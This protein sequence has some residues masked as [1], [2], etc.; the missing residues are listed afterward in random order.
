MPQIIKTVLIFIFLVI[1]CCISAHFSLAAD[2]SLGLEYGEMTGLGQED[3]R[4][5]IANIIRIVLG[6]LGIV[7]VGLI[8]YAGWLWMSAEGNSEK[9]D[10]AKKVLIGAV[11]GLIICL[12]AFAIASFILSK[13][14]E[15]TSTS[16]PGGGYLDDTS[17]PGGGYSTLTR[18]DANTLTPECDIDSGFCD[19]NEYCG[20]DC[21][22]H[23]KGGYGDSCDGDPV[24]SECEVSS[25]MCQ[26]YLE[27][28]S[29]QDCE[30]L[31]APVIEWIS[32]VDVDNTPNGAPGNLITVGGRYFG[33]SV[34]EVIFAGKDTDNDGELFG[35]ADDQIASFPNEVNA[36][37]INYWQDNQIIV[38]VPDEAVDGPIKV[39]RT[40][41]E[42]DTTI[43]SRGPVIN[44]FDVNNM[45]RPG[46]CLVEP[47]KGYYGDVFALEGISFAGSEKQVLFGNEANNIKA[48]SISN[49]AD[50]SVEAVVPNINSGDNSI[51]V[52]IDEKNS[53]SLFFEVLYDS[54]DNPKIDYINPEK[55]PIGQYVTIYGSNFKN[56]YTDSSLVQFYLPADPDNLIYADID[57]VEECLEKFWQDTYIIVKVPKV[58]LG[59]YKVIVTNKDG[60]VSEPAD[61]TVT[62]GDPGPGTC[63][64]DPHNGP[65][66]QAVSV[67]GDNFGD[68]QDDGKTVFYNEISDTFISSWT[69]QKIETQVPTEAQTGSFKVVKDGNN[70]NTLQFTVGTCSSSDQCYLG[71]ECCSSDTYWAGICRDEGEC[72][73]EA[74]SE[75]VFGWTF[76]TAADS[77]ILNCSGYNT[78]E[79]CISTDM[80]PNSPGQCQTR[81]EASAGECGDDYCNNNYVECD[82]NCV[83]DGS[84]NQCKL[85]NQS[86]DEFNSSLILSYKAECRLVDNQVIW[87]IDSNEIS[88]PIGSFLDTNNWCSVG[89]LGVPEEC[90]LCENDFECQES[91]CVIDNQICPD[92]STCDN[93]ECVLD[94]SVC[95]C[96]CRVG[97]D[98]QDCC[99][100]LTCNPGNCGP[101]APDYGLC[102]G[103]RV[104]IDGQVNQVVSD[105]ACNCYGQPSRY[106]EV[107]DSD[108]PLGVCEDQVGQ[109]ESC[110]ADSSLASC[111]VNNS[112]CQTG[113]YCEQDSCTCQ[114][115]GSFGDSCDGDLGQSDCQI[116]NSMCQTGLYCEQDSCTCQVGGGGSGDLCENESVPACSI[117]ES[118]CLDS[119]E[120][121]NNDSDDCRCC[122]NPA[123]DQCSAPLECWANQT[124]CEGPSR[125][126]CCGCSSDSQC[127]GGIDGCGND[128]CCRA[129]PEI[130]QVNPA[131]NAVDVCKNILIS[132][133]FDQ[134]MD[135]ASFAENFIVA[136]DYGENQCPS[137][138]NFL[139]S[140]NKIKNKFI[141]KIVQILKP[142]FGERLVVLASENH[143][144]CAIDG[145]VDGYNNQ[146]G[147]G[148]ITF[149]PDNILDTDILYYAIVSGDNNITDSLVSGVSNTHG[150][151]MFG[152]DNDSFNAKQF[153]NS[154][155]WSFTVGQDICQLDYITVDPA[156]YLF[157]TAYN[158][159]VDDDLNSAEY[160]TE[161]DGDKVF[162]AQALTSSG[163][164]IVSFSGI[165]SWDWDWQIDNTA[166]VDFADG[167]QEA[168]SSHQI[169][170]AQNQQDAKTTIYAKAT[171]NE[172]IIL[173]PSTVGQEE[174]GEAE[175]YVFMCANPWP[176][177]SITN[178]WTPWQD[179]ASNCSPGLEGTGCIDNN[180]E[181]YYCRDAGDIGT[182]DDL[183]A[184]LNDT[185][186]RGYS[187]SLNLLK[188]YYFLRE[189]MPLT[190]VI[191]VSD[192]Q[193]G[194]KVAVSWLS[195]SGAAGY[196]LYYGKTSGSYD[197]F[198]DVENVTS[199][200]ISGLT[201]GQIYYF[202]VTAY[203][204]TKAESEYSN[205]ASVTPTDSTS[206]SAITNLD[207]SAGDSMVSLNWSEKEDAV[208]YKIYYGTAS[209]LYGDIT[210]I[211]STDSCENYNCDYSLEDLVN[212]TDYYITITALDVYENESSKSNEI[213]LT[214]ISN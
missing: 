95:E 45:V 91:Q 56:Y 157:Q 202:T 125:G 124:P 138:T 113:L 163:E 127:S 68:N 170:L 36:N 200:I 160:D 205:E 30:C 96:C 52:N 190:T 89:V 139:A 73:K 58:D 192:Q 186:V 128:S 78:V 46:L 210:E 71:E 86:C 18:C 33:D 195:V 175:I 31:G 88:C 204:S 66:G 133:T 6:F 177:T 64:L 146:D 176:P 1:V 131:D 212:T 193:T 21:Y 153:I 103:C 191:T 105:Q 98:A 150:I 135:I 97:Y 57:F 137:G 42:S 174:T 82:N 110:D 15:A 164:A 11:I 3:P 179:N 4:I 41:S 129:R 24:T 148:V 25:D 40:D 194:G 189:D 178:Y 37:C 2:D 83:Y 151:G 159:P 34:G 77:N 85:D 143:N 199:K 17:F 206:P 84:I 74:V 180:F 39:V 130:T 10:Q 101:G 141:A 53:N 62:N 209:G 94:N 5:I 117:G 116:N 112:M 126:L 214:P 213:N 181:L 165:Y 134:E 184:I 114:V 29:D 12:S 198:L 20:N 107:N 183:P 75:C 43:D 155:I 51:F 28:K 171:V 99:A 203:Y 19:E 23:E 161:K 27:C 59:D 156:S 147:L 65:V 50:M 63:L 140:E 13:I 61:F 149:A 111:Q 185:I 22:C 211:D 197:N 162:Y 168:N 108:Y 87:Q 80:C 60:R 55:G 7:A 49:W 119:L 136:G 196:K 173:N 93:N 47:E 201:N 132:A 109:G 102:T 79:A 54:A 208:T 35:D 152:Q 123:D 182:A 158:N 32:P 106:C 144:Y 100:G 44:D 76:S 207:G 142:V 8:V 169:I 67:Y 38:I 26:A 48:D 166:V 115:G 145:K 70:S 172:D 118:S 81:S 121:L 188:E 16:L 120:C 69:S 92:N 9:I 154:E 14:M 187:D 104:I 167:N 72:S 122:C 90:S